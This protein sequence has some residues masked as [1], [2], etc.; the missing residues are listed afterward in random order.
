MTAFLAMC[1]TTSRNDSIIT[2][3]FRRIS[4]RYLRLAPLLAFTILVHSTWLYRLGSGPIWNQFNFSERQFCRTNFWANLLFLDNYINVE[5]KCLLQSWYLAVDFWLYAF[6]SL[7]LILIS[8]KPSATNW[9]LLGVI[10][11]SAMSIA[12]T[13][14]FNKLEPVAIF[15]PE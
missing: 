1:R 9:L 4:D 14:Y 10:S 2:V 3:L 11:L 15:T 13:V 8:R 6:A 5:Q 7:C 12:L